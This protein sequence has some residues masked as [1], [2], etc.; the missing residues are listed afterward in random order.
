MNAL[1]Q[2][3]STELAHLRVDVLE[4]RDKYN[5]LSKVL[6]GYSAAAAHQCVIATEELVA[7]HADLIDMV[8][9][10]ETE[11]TS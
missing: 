6:T 7:R 5:Y 8:W 3:R 11:P 10:D 2:S 9:R 1:N 4:L